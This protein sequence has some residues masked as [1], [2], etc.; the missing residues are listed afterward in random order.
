MFFRLLYVIGL[1]WIIVLIVTAIVAGSL[2]VRPFWPAWLYW[3]LVTV[4][5]A[6]VFWPRPAR[7]GEPRP[8]SD[9]L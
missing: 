1:L 5:G 9:D 4:V 8:G 2:L 3:L 6:I 7:P